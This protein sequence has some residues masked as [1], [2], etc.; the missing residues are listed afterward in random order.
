M[1]CDDRCRGRLDVAGE[2]RHVD[3]VLPP[4]GN[5]A[6][7]REG[8][9][10]T[11]QDQRRAVR[12][13]VRSPGMPGRKAE[14]FGLPEDH[15]IGRFEEAAR[16][17]GAT[18]AAGTSRL[19]GDVLRCARPGAAAGRTATRSDSDHH[20]RRGSEDAPAGCPPRRHL[21]LVRHGAERSRGV[22]A[23]GGGTRGGMPRYRAKSCVDRAIRGIIVEPTGRHRAPTISRRSRSWHPRRDRRRRSVRSA[24]AA[25]R[26]RNPLWPGRWPRSRR[27]LRCWS[28]S[29]PTDRRWVNA[30]S[31]QTP[32]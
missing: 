29:T 22:R 6:N 7:H 10:D 8:G 13:R 30:W 15:V 19:R 16:D 24:P 20:R 14:A 3:P 17:H 9:R 4:F 32:A 21:E 23:K 11:G 5:P 1:R 25:S 27:W 12:F 18:P 26:G 31:G 2:R 28:C